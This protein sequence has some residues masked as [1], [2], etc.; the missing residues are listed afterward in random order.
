MLNR[1]LAH[2]VTTHPD[3]VA[4]ITAEE[5]TVTFAD[6]DHLSGE[7]A[8]WLVE[9]GVG[10]GS[11]VALMLPSSPEYVVAYLGLARVGAV[12]AGINP[13]LAPPERATILAR[14]G[15]SHLF[16]TTVLAD[17]LDGATATEAGDVEILQS[18]DGAVAEPI[19]AGAIEV[20]KVDLAGSAA[21]VL[22][23]FRSPGPPPP[24]PPEDPDRPVAVVFTSGTT[25][26]PKGAL[27]RN[28]QFQAALE[29]EN[30]D[31]W[32][33]GRHIL[34]GTQFSHVGFMLRLAAYLV[35]G[36]TLCMVDKWRA[37]LALELIERY[38]MPA[39]NGVAA[40]VALLLAHPN[41]AERDLSSV[42]RVVVGGGPS[43][44]KLIAAALAEWGGTYSLRYSSTESGG[45][46]TA[47][48]Y[49]AAVEDGPSNVGHP[50]GDVEL[51]IV[52]DGREQPTGEVGELLLRSGAMLSEYW[53][54][55]AATAAKIVDGWLRTGD[56]GFLDETGSLHLA[57]RS[58]EMY[59][60][61][62]YNVYP[63]EPESVLAPH[64]GVAQI[65]IVGRPDP[66][67]GEI[68]VAVVVPADGA[69]P[70]LAE[71]RAFAKGQL[72][73]FKLPEVLCVLD[74]LPLTNGQKL[75]RRTL[76]DLVAEP[77][78]GEQ[79]LR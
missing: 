63:H 1:S 72:A 8:T 57:G 37:E 40:Q 24:S 35:Q 42:E 16:S 29:V 56:L 15:A 44:P 38:R 25:G 10:P 48:T 5:W 21:G 77:L 14:T 55:P 67:M 60:R 41:L 32:A 39:I 27:F 74:E 59:I 61:G 64:A 26:L 33:A 20:L 36:T 70:D 79:R 30:G 51:R 49:D 6:L 69:A 46:G 23:A 66:V 75:D 78:P 28:R 62:G 73:A 18:K 71:L 9:Q 17:P 58:N 54:D 11:V 12:T 52:V 31:P 4:L 65:A 3:R 43:A 7:V 50:R 68:G 47:I 45:V 34:S 13:L 2:A 76:V 19:D 22:A 53:R